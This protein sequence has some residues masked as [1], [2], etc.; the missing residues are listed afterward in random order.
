M[1]IPGK[2]VEFW[3]ERPHAR[4]GRVAMVLSAKDG[5]GKP[6]D[7]RGDL[8]MRVFYGKEMQFAKFQDQI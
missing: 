1:T 2:V 6:L 4:D 7:Y 3:P 8:S 5:Q